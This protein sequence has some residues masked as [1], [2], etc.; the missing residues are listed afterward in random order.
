MGKNFQQ[1]IRVV[2]RDKVRA[3][4]TVIEAAFFDANGNPIPVGAQANNVS[5]VSTADATDLATAQALA[6]Q[7]KTTVNAI[8]T[9]L[10]NAKLMKSS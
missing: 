8:L 1:Q 2:S 3:S 10:K 4:T 7:L 6:N 5:A 9:S